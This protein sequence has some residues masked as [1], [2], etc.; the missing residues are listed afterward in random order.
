ML[1]RECAQLLMA[2]SLPQCSH[3]VLPCHAAIVQCLQQVPNA[4]FPAAMATGGHQT[5]LLATHGLGVLT[6]M[7]TACPV[8][9]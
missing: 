5:F 3:T 2:S 7:C 8:L 6:L 1:L 4:Y 9:L